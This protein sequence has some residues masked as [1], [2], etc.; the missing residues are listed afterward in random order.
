MRVPERL[1]E[2]AL[3]L[4]ADSP[5]RGEGTAS[6]GAAEAPL[7]GR[8]LLGGPLA[9]VLT[10][11]FVADDSE[12]KA[13]VAQEAATAVY[14]LVHLGLTVTAPAGRPPLHSIDLRLEL[15]AADGAAFQPVAWS[16]SPRHLVTGRTAER[17]L[18]LGPSLKLL[19]AEVSVGSASWT[20]SGADGRPWLRAVRE[21]RSDPAWEFR[22]VSGA[23]LEGEHRLAAV[24][25][26]P[27]GSATTLGLGVTA[28]VRRRTGL[29]RKY[30]QEL[31]EPLQSAVDL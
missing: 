16:L 30:V 31:V 21:L 18:S 3:V 29:L 5:A 1:S 27:R 12:L 13:F 23:E 22:R 8:V 11:E 17:T 7:E 24:V 2:R 4:A 26:T 25:R 10:E 28:A 15:T 6:T 14:H 19:G 20:T 9:V